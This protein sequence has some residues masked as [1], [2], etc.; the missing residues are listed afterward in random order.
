M[1]KFEF[2]T[3]LAIAE[4]YSEINTEFSNEWF[5]QAAEMSGSAR[6]IL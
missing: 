6:G 2:I 5:L 4:Y 3:E 1:L